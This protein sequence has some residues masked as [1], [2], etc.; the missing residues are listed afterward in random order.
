MIRMRKR[1]G[2]KQRGRR[3]GESEQASAEGKWEGLKGGSWPS[4]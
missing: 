4:Y 2:E 1:E 3:E